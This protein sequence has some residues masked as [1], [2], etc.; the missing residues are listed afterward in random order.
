MKIT[1]KQNFIGYVDFWGNLLKKLIYMCYDF[2]ITIK[3]NC[4]MKKLVALLLCLCF[5]V[6]T[7]AACNDQPVGSNE[8]S[9]GFATSEV[10]GNSDDNP[11]DIKDNNNNGLDLPNVEAVKP[12]T[13]DLSDTYIM[14][15]GDTL[16]SYYEKTLDDFYS[17]CKYYQES[18]KYKLYS[19][20]EMNGNYFATY[21]KDTYL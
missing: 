14:G 15:G 4:P 10:P 7:F 11:G 17:T 5:C 20:H 2:I 1:K 6:S 13:S 18:L 19:Y 3:E 9:D 21:Q 16:K 12:S 8:N